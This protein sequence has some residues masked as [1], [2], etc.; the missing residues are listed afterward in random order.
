[1][2]RAPRVS[3]ESTIALTPR[4]FGT[5]RHRS[6]QNLYDRGVT[7]EQAV[8]SFAVVAGLLTIIPGLDTTLVLR[9]TLR[10]GRQAGYATALGIGTGSLLW[11]AAA[12]AGAAALLAVS[13]FAYQLITIAGAVYLVF[14]GVNMIIK[15]FRGPAH[16]DAA[17]DEQPQEPSLLRLWLTGAGVNLLNPKVGVFYIAT[18]PQFIPD[19]VPALP[20]GVLLAAV[21]SL[22]G[23]IW[24][25][26]IILGTGFAGRWLRNARAAKIIDRIAG[27]VLIGFGVRLVL[28]RH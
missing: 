2:A 26:V 6:Q 10:H 21:H 25:S 19:G 24:F 20:M 3:S 28:A 11:G 13:R 22:E 9:S 16:V 4:I 23:M 8:L 15:T 7:T 18:L 1:M 17:A 27:V 12:A 14:L 5:R